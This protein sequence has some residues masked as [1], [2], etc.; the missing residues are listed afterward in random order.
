MK[1]FITTLFITAVLTGIVGICLC[2]HLNKKE[3][4]KQ[5]EIMQVDSLHSQITIDSSYHKYNFTVSMDGPQG[6]LEPALY[7]N[8]N[9]KLGGTNYPDT[10]IPY[11]NN[12]ILVSV[13]TTPDKR[14]T[15]IYTSA[16]YINYLLS[17]PEYIY[18][19]QFYNL[20][21]HKFTWEDLIFKG[22]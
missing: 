22:F 20:N 16:E 11:P 1:T 19:S 2:I 5:P 10:L 18:R 14:D 15:S 13:Y 9:I 3:R 8:P 12:D 6:T 7:G 21:Q 4:L 17:N